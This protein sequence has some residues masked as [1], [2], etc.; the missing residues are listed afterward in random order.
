M[1]RCVSR[2]SR[3][4]RGVTRLGLVSALGADSKSSVFY[5]RV[6]GDAEQAIAALGFE[7]MVIARP[8]MLLGDRTALGQPARHRR[9]HRLGTVSA[10]SGG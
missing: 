4:R 3:K 5:N 1:P 10:P 8:S 7:S 9:A 6:K 2:G